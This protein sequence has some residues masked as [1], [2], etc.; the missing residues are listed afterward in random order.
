M[1]DKNEI[2]ANLYKGFANVTFTKK[3]GSIRE[4]TCTL[5][6][7]HLPERIIDENVRHVPRQENEDVLAVWDVDNKS[8]RSFRLDSVTEIKYMYPVFRN[9]T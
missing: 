3:D 1:F 4:M 7:D 6:S 9:V 2:R 5:M 8:W